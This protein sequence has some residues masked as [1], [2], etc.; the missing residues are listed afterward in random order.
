MRS[1]KIWM[2][3]NIKLKWDNYWNGVSLTNNLLHFMDNSN[4]YKVLEDFEFGGNDYKVGSEVQLRE[5][6]ANKFV[7][8]GKLELVG[9]VKEDVETPPSEG[10]TND[11][12]KPES[13]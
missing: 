7:E 1:R 9:G 8:E 12:E 5:S 3:K 6:D 13:E 11:G 10:E 2:M 4:V